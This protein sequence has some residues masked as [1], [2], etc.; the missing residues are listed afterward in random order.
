MEYRIVRSR[1][2]TLALELQK[3]GTLLVRAP[4]AAPPSDI[5][6]FVYEHAAWIESRRERLRAIML[7]PLTPEEERAL[8]DRAT[9]DLP[10]RTA[11]WAK[12]MGI[13]YTGVKITSAR[14]RLG[15]CNSKGGIAYS[16]RL[17]QYPDEVID[18]VVVHELSHRKEMNHSARFY[19]IIERYLPDYRRTVDKMKSWPRA[20]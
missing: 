13:E 18:Y 15:S 16:F 17:M 20:L 12:R 5:E 7:S 4:Y 3:D 1:R 19:A 8:R 11:V 10:L 6:K 9:A 2:R 14:N